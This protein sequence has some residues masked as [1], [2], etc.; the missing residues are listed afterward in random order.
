M[1]KNLR[2]FMSFF[3]WVENQDKIDWQKWRDEQKRKLEMGEEIE[4]PW[5]FAPNSDPTVIWISWRHGNYWLNE[6]WQ[7]FWKKL[8]NK[9]KKEYFE[10]WHPPD[11]GW[12]ENVVV[13]WDEG[14]SD[15]SERY[16]E[17]ERKFVDGEAIEPPWVVF[18]LSSPN[19]GWDQGFGETWKLRIWLPFWKRLSRTQQGEYLENWQPPTDDWRK[20]LT[21]FWIDKLRKTER[22]HNK[23]LESERWHG[24]V[25][26]PWGAFPNNSAIYEWEEGEREKWLQRVW[27][28]YWDKLSDEKQ[29]KYLEHKTSADSEWIDI[30]KNH[31]IRNL[32]KIKNLKQS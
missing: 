32:E 6:I 31:Q 4:P 16:K 23:Q 24:E 3:G 8:N 5:I 18:P 7:P 26:I 29:D 14:I 30:L 2:K 10:R 11:D 19:Y 15:I 22:W 20:T 28:P 17:Q 12:Y 27:L 1:N 21:I 9:E 25:E 13:Y